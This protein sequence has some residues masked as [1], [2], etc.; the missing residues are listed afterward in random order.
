LDE[1][2]KNLTDIFSKFGKILDIVAMS[3]FSRK[4][5]AFVVYETVEEAEKAMASL[6]N[7]PFPSPEKSMRI[8]FA[9]SKSDATAKA[10][11]TY[12]KREKR[13]LPPKHTA[14]GSDGG[15]P[16][17]KLAPAV[18]GDV[19]MGGAAVDGSGGAEAQAYAGGGAP[20]AGGDAPPPGGVA[21]Y[22]QPPPGAGGAGGVQQGQAAPAMDEE[23]P[24]SIL[25]MTGLPEGTNEAMLKELFNR[26]VLFH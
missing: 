22:G 10:D 25:F 18:G 4:G 21:F 23:V 16:R 7:F 20:P 5:Q 17:K 24:N 26:C 12:T 13:A 19:A 11:G 15:A 1:L 2:K 8:A 3:S 9:R 14:V 6:Q